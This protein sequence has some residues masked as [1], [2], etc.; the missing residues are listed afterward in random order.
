ML[1]TL[2][3]PL[4]FL[5]PEVYLQEMEKLWTDE[6][7]IEGEWRRF[8]DS[9]LNEWNDMITPVFYPPDF[10]PNFLK[11]DVTATVDCDA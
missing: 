10:V 8:I 4:L 6:V 3:S 11:A 7:I 2:L 9:V 5:G 1:I